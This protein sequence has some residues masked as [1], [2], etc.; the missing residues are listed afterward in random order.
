MVEAQQTQITDLPFYGFITHPS[1][2]LCFLPELCVIK[3]KPGGIS[4]LLLPSTNLP[5]A[6]SSI[7]GIE[8]LREV[9][10]GQHVHTCTLLLHCIQGH[11]H[12]QEEET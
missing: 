7:S 9:T 11:L 4:P 3:L 10:C 5:G 12:E 1:K 8:V 6:S 2:P